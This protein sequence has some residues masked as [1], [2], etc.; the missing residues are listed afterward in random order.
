MDTATPKCTLEKQ[1]PRFFS[2]RLTKS[3]RF[4]NLHIVKTKARRMMGIDAADPRLPVAWKRRIRKWTREPA[5]HRFKTVDG[6]MTHL[7]SV[8]G[9]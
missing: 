2:P 9:K 1:F 3:D 6:L 7:K 8:C 5:A 4:P